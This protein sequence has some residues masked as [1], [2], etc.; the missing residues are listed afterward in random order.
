MGN[1]TYPPPEET[2]PPPPPPPDGADTTSG[3]E[4]FFKWYTH[5]P[6]AW[7]GSGVAVLGLGLGVGFS[8]GASVVQGKADEH[9]KSIEDDIKTNP[10]YTTIPDPNFP[11]DPSKATKLKPCGPLDDASTDLA[12][13]HEACDILRKDLNDLSTNNIMMGVGWSLFGVGVVGTGLYALFDWYLPKKP[14]TTATVAPSGPRIL[15]VT[16][17]VGSG[18][19]GLGIVGT[20]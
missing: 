4:P 17:S 14:A 6:I 16:P 19:Q 9:S 18:Y 20:F 15:A 5:K 8:I 1:T 2:P 13:Y 3:R 11:N 12:R 7:V 10:Q